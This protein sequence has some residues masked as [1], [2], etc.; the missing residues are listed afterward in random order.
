MLKLCE[1]PLIEKTRHRIPYAGLVWE[2]DEFFADNAGLIVA[3]V[4]LESEQQQFAKPA[5][6]GVEVSHDKRYANANLLRHPYSQ[7]DK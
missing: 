4:E 5:W 6:L 3:E 2:V 1:P 7:W